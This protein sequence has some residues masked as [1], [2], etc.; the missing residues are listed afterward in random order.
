MWGARMNVLRIQV[1]ANIGRVEISKTRLWNEDVNNEM[2]W[3]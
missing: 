1:L 2:G 3:F